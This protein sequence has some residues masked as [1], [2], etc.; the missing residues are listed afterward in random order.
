MVEAFHLYL[1][2]SGTRHPDKKRGRAPS[3]NRDWFGMGGILLDQ[4]QEESEKQ[5]IK[6][7]CEKWN[8]NKYLRS[9][10]IRGHHGHFSFIGELEEHERKEFLEELYCLMRSFDKIGFACVIDRPGYK[11]RYDNIYGQNKWLLCKTT[12][13]VVTERAAKW[14]KEHNKKLRI[15]VE[16]SDKKTDNRIREY[17]KELKNNG[18]PFNQKSS[19][20]YEPLTIEELNNTLYDLKFKNKSSRLA[21]MA[22]LYL[23]PMCIGGYDKS[24]K[25]YS[26]LLKDNKL[27]DCFLD[28]ERRPFLGIK[29]SCWEL[30]K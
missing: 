21:Q 19:S 26:R 1:D 10:D 5:A 29:Y 11:K 9:A 30:A 3:H 16:E 28:Q 2:D 8:I 6:L 20:K 25:T 14:A 22:D 13:S 24:N 18:M 12:F 27:I 7:F 15:F 17:Y 4:N 23:W